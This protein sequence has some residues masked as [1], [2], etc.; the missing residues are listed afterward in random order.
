MGGPISVTICDIY[1]IKMEK[2]VVK[3]TKPK[4]YGRFVE[5]IYV[6]RKKDQGDQLFYKMNNYCKNIKLKKIATDFQKEVTSV[7][8]EFLKA[9]SLIKL[10]NSVINESCNETESTEDSYI[11][12]PNLFKEEKCIV[13]IK[14]PYC[15]KNEKKSKDFLKKVYSFRGYNFRLLITWKTSKIQTLFDVKEKSFYPSCKIY[16][17]MCDYGENYTN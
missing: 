5:D 15:E 12:P 13:M 10:I 11:I 7:C 6:R 9:D 3:P 17:D 14:I 2:D 16:Y 4:F 1:M 8:K